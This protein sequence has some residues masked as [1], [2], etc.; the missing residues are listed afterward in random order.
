[1]PLFARL[2]VLRAHGQVH[3]LRTTVL[4]ILRC[5]STT[6]H[7]SKSSF[8]PNLNFGLSSLAPLPRDISSPSFSHLVTSLSATTPQMIKDGARNPAEEMSERDRTFARR[9]VLGL[10]GIGGL[11]GLGVF[12]M[13]VVSGNASGDSNEQQEDN[14][15]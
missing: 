9:I 4:T 14:P 5:S 1:M 2:H 7:K 6:P 10:C 8:I 11:M 13:G 15:H 12:S 3:A